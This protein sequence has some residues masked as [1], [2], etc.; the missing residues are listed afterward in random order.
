VPRVPFGVAIM[1]SNGLPE[2]AH[3]VFKQG[4]EGSEGTLVGQA[5][6]GSVCPNCWTRDEAASMT[7]S[8]DQREA[9]IREE[10]D[11]A[12]HSPVDVQSAP[13]PEPLDPNG[14]M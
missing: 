6:G 8:L 14:S 2:P 4:A 1:S 9:A 5:G 10:A 7:A 3:A 11:D 12:W 13:I